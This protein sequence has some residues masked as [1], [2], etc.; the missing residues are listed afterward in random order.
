VKKLTTLILLLLLYS[1]LN[2][3]LWGCKKNDLVLPNIPTDTTAIDS[4]YS[5]L[6]D[7]MGISTKFL[8]K[9]PQRPFPFGNTYNSGVI[10]PDI[11]I[12]SRN[13]RVIEFYHKWR[14][15]YLKTFDDSM[16]Y[17]HYTLEYEVGDAI[18]CSEGHGFGM[19]ITVL[20]AGVDSTQYNDFI[21]LYRWFNCHRSNINSKLMAWQQNSNGNNSSGADSATD[22]DLDIAYALLLAHYQWGSDGEVNFLAEAI[23]MMEA[24]YQSDINPNYK[25]IELGD[26][27]S[28][29]KYA[30]STRFCDF[31]LDHLRAFK[32]A[33]NNNKWNEIIDTAYVIVNQVAD[34]VTG[35]YPDFA[36]NI[37]GKFQPSSPDFLEGPNDGDYYYNSCRAPWRIATDYIVYGDSR[38][39]NVLVRLNRWIKQETKGNTSQIMG[40]YKLNGTALN[41][42]S[43]MA[44][45]APFGVCAMVDDE[46]QE[47]LNAMWNQINNETISS[48]AYFGNSIKML[49]LITMSG[50]W[51]T[52]E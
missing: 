49:S 23:E 8:Y 17:I 2:A 5:N 3:T 51:W 11:P 4:N 13:N 34:S 28:S 42:W 32:C 52:A 35:L 41:N 24:I 1:F 46:N 21:K 19:V 15:R 10:L 25:Q 36:V 26:W 50:N 12:D 18:S 6:R 14:S 47:W 31:M 29:G 45:T 20:M 33:T 7:A 48:G 39:Q 38:A 16:C 40:G 43:D 37:N 22:G 30:E 44:F 27:V 9:E